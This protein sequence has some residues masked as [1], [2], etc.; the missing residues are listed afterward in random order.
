MFRAHSQSELAG[1]Q[2]VF[3]VHALLASGLRS[4][5]CVRFTFALFSCRLLNAAEQ[6]GCVDLST[7]GALFYCSCTASRGEC[8]YLCAEHA[9]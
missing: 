7:S 9:F 2:T 8:I 4:R 1:R 6:P 5:L 3:V